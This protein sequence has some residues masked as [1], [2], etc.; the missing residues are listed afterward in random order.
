MGIRDQV[1]ADAIGGS[2]SDARKRQQGRV[3]CIKQVALTGRVTALAERNRPVGA[4]T[5]GRQGY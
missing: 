2:G 5:R 1:E 3:S 4:A